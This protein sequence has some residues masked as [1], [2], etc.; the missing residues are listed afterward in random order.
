MPCI[1]AEHRKT[2]RGIP[3]YTRYAS[4]DNCSSDGEFVS[5][6]VQ[7]QIIINRPQY[8]ALCAGWC[9][10]SNHYASTCILQT[11]I[12]NP[13][14][15]QDKTRSTPSLTGPLHPTL[16]ATRGHLFTPHSATQPS[17]SIS[18]T[19]NPVLVIPLV[20]TV[21]LRLGDSSSDSLG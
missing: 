5:R 11:Q 15:A 9:L 8:P 18:P 6:T 1:L 21:G 16:P 3:K 14:K 2:W 17:R 20:V 10:Y 13:R 4:S 7:A 12:T 19:T